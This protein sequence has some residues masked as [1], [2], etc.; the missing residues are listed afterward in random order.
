MVDQELYDDTQ[1]RMKKSIDSMRK[2]FMMVRTGR[3]T[4]VVLEPIKISAYGQEM[5]IKQVASVSIPE[6]RMIVIQPWDKG[7]LADI[8][9]AIQ[10]SDLG[11]N[12]SNDGKIIRL[13]FPPLTED[14]RKELVKQ[15]KKRSEEGRVAVRNVRRDAMEMLK[16]MQ[17]EGMITEDD[18]KRGQA[19][20]EELTKK[21]IEEID[22]VL[23]AKE[24]EV[25]EV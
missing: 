24:K 6:P 22:K 1:D 5:P 19:E 9:K 4:P 18:E 3:A 8:E 14:R 16:E 15:L 23:E 20:F 7:V 17:K 12:P 2:D 11:I 10:K 13:V 25:M 21:M